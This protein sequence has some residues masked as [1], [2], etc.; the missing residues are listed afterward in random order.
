MGVLFPRPF[1]RPYNGRFGRWPQVESVLTYLYVGS[2]TFTFAAYNS[3]HSP[4]AGWL[5]MVDLD[6]ICGSRKI[7]LPLCRLKFFSPLMPT[8]R[9]ILR[10]RAGR[11]M[12]DLGV[13]CGSRKI[14]LPLCRLKFFSPLMPT[15]RLILLLRAGRVW[16]I[17]V[18]SV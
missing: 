1:P 6:V 3:T 15:T 17:W 11:I 10:P 4:A 13:I 7:H 12:V 14:H 2:G 9:L 16:S 8:T 5:C 18:L